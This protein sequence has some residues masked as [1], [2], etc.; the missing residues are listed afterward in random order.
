MRYILRFDDISPNMAWSKFI[1]LK[2]E[3][4]K[5]GVK[6]VLGVIPDCLDNSLYVEPE[7]KDFFYYIR[8]CKKYGDTI[9]Q[10]GTHHVY[11]SNNPGILRI[12]NSSEFSGLT[13]KEQYIKLKIGKEILQKK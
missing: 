9:S 2:N 3:L 11:C 4:T 12:N 10:H 6:S 7:N 8:Q 5:L 1:P 13:Y